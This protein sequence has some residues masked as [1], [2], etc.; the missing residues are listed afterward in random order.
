MLPLETAEMVTVRT[1]LLSARISNDSLNRKRYG[2]YGLGY[3]DLGDVQISY[4]AGDERKELALALEGF[5]IAYLFFRFAG[6]F[7]P[8]DIYDWLV[9]AF[10][11]SSAKR[12]LENSTFDGKKV[13]Y[14]TNNSIP[15]RSPTCSASRLTRQWQSQIT[16]PPTTQNWML[17]IVPWM[18]TRRTATR[19]AAT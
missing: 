12:E 3:D 17:R 1:A 16:H 10:L 14:A 18:R 2:V 13:D 15:C 5:P 4:S 9:K 7:W 11:T 6:N 8:P 19:S